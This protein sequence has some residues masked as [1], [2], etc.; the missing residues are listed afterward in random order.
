MAKRFNR[1]VS[2]ATRF[3]MSL[4]KKGSKNPMYK[5]HHEVLAWHQHILEAPLEMTGLS[6]ALLRCFDIKMS[7]I[8]KDT[9][10]ESF[11]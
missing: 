10:K 9:L 2:E 1:R 6:V 7:D 8:L 11:K 5:K 4:A 3:R